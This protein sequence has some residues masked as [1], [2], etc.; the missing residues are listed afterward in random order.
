MEKA[1]IIII[2]A[3]VVGLA[4][5]SSIAKKNRNVFIIERHES[6]GRETSSRNSEVIHAGIYYPQN[7]IKGKLCVE[8]NRMM[9]EICSKYK[10]PHKNSG[11]LIVAV[12]EKEEAELP[13][14]LD[15]AINNGAEGIKIISSAEVK[16]LEPNIYARAA[17]FCPTS[18]IVDS[19]SMMQFFEAD[20]IDKGANTIYGAE[21]ISLEKSSVYWTVGIKER[22]GEIS[23]IKSSIVINSA[24]L[25][26]SNIAALAGID[27]EKSNYKMN[28]RK[29]IYFRATRQLEKFPSMLIYPVPPE[30]NAVGI[31]TTP[32][33]AGGMRLGPHF[34]YINELD[35]IVDE[36]FRDFFFESSHSYLPF[37]E[38]DDLQP[39]IAGIIPT[40]PNPGEP[41]RDFVI[42]NESDNGLSGLINLIGIDSP[43]LTASPAIGKYVAQLIDN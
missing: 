12:N 24:G 20:A 16:R 29:G 37:L 21:V 23:T 15:K 41:M 36:S 6:F 35:Y 8:G 39:D 27:L 5:A 22:S 30:S 1:D 4:I 34:Y 31:H 28:Y 40:L 13:S 11:K 10:I 19:H 14:L 17:L 18:G 2:G 7:F 43:G 38:I 26:C 25:D 3:G 9:Y 33:L 42:K 32:D